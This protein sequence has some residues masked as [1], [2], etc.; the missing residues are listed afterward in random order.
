M[1]WDKRAILSLCMLIMLVAGYNLY[2]Y[3]LFWGDWFILHTKGMYYA[4]AGSVMLYLTIND[5][6]GHSTEIQFEIDIICKITLVINFIIFAVSLF[7]MLPN[8]RLY[9]YLFNGCIFVTSLMVL[10]SGCRHEIFKN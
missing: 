7:D 4:V 1:T 6:I 8:H 9:L 2:I 10:Y 5:I 3:E